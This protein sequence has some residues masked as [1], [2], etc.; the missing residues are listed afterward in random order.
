MSNVKYCVMK[1]IFLFNPRDP[2]LVNYKYRTY[3]KRQVISS[4]NT[5]NKQLLL[6]NN[7]QENQTLAQKQESYSLSSGNTLSTKYFKNIVM[8][9]SVVS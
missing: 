5:C 4:K 1:I 8:I 9:N 2:C 7:V 6:E 3:I